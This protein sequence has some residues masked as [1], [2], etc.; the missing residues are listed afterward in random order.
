MSGLFSM[1]ALVWFVLGM[2]AAWAFAKF[3][4]SASS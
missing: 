2:L 4:P 3:R 1:G